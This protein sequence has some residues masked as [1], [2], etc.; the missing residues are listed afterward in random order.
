MEACHFI[1]LRQAIMTSP[2]TI[3]AELIH[4]RVMKRLH[5]NLQNLAQ[6]TAME[7]DILREVHSIL[8]TS[9]LLFL[10]Y[11]ATDASLEYSQALPRPIGKPNVFVPT[12][13][14]EDGS[15][16]K[17]LTSG[18]FIN[19]E[20]PLTEERLASLA[21]FINA[22][23]GL[24]IPLKHSEKLIGLI[25]AYNS[26][27]TALPPETV[28]LAQAISPSL[29]GLLQ[30]AK[31]QADTQKHLGAIERET[32]IFSRID[33]EL[34]DI[35]DLNYVFTMLKDWALRFTNADAASLS[36]Y[37]AEL[38]SLRIMS[39]YGYP[40]G[41]IQ[42]NHEL[43]GQ[44]GGITLR[45]ARSGIDEIVPD[46]SN[47]PDYYELAAGMRTQ[48]SVPIKREE[49][50]I[51]VLNLL[52]TQLNGFTEG[53]LEFVKR[54]ANRGGVAVDNA[55]L[56]A[57]TTREREKLQY[58]V[59]NIG[60]IIIV[61]GLDNHI[62][63][64]N[65]AAIQAF[66][67]SADTDYT[68]KL[69]N[70][71]LSH[72]KLQL[73][74]QLAIETQETSSVELELPNGRTYHTKIEYHKNVGRIIVMQDISHF[75][76]TERLKTELVA[77]VSHDLKQPLSVM[78]GYLDLLQMVNEFD[79]KSLGY[80][81]NLNYAFNN[82]RQLI[83]DLLDIARIE[84]GIKLDLEQVNI[85]EVLNRAIRNNQHLSEQKKQTL[86]L[87]I[88]DN[89]PSVSGDP[90]RLEQIFNN[91]VSNA[92]KYTP[93]EGKVRVYAELKQDALRI[94]VEDSGLGIGAEDQAQIFERFYRVRRPETDSIE[95]TGLGLAIVKSLVEAH[96]GKIDLKS[97]LGEGSTFRVT[98]PLQ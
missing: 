50:V 57:E 49:R 95:G 12:F 19:F 33:E 48:M 1:L 11:N 6:S 24:L 90:S 60:D 18:E 97:A 85:I 31:K 23:H 3:E 47:D 66:H 93:P 34:A 53:H 76:E 14:A 25:V 82:M 37:D 15:I 42:P 83:D 54:L 40:V 45:V 73:S 62:I 22:S 2:Q 74:Y 94:F 32:E 84:A 61:L 92:V 27:E 56:F 91:L 75:K 79:K 77:T 69:F 20:K 30:M 87:E 59:Q 89:V 55:R 36:L 21:R 39:H 98:L 88:P 86:S 26:D 10:T 5:D 4:L 51:A 52:S 67:L 35:I 65:A 13:N 8:G 7:S 81:D 29:L 44:Q 78:R 9:H 71:V 68:G 43:T 72:Q 28:S 70:D 63:L 80:V 46:L 64:I 16:T 96:E 41:A 17:R 38:N 58:I